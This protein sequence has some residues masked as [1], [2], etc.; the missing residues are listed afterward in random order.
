MGV[1]FKAEHRQMKRVVALKIVS[2]SAIKSRDAL[3]RFY[4]EVE[5]AA[6]LDHPNV[7]PALDAGEARGTHFLVMQYVEGDDLS[8]HVKRRGRLPVDEAVDCILQAAQGLQYAHSRGIIHRDIK[9]ANL[10]LDRQGTVKILDMRL[11]RI[12]SRTDETNADELTNTGAVMGTAAYMSPEQA[13][14]ARHAD[15]RSDIYSLGCTLHYLLTGHP[16]YDGDTHVKQILAHREQP[17]PSLRGIRPEVPESVD[18]IFA[19]MVAKRPVDRFQSMR[20]VVQALSTI[21]EASTTFSGSSESDA[22]GTSGSPEKQLGH[23]PISATGEATPVAALQS[24][25]AD[26]LTTQISEKTGILPSKAPPDFRLPLRGAGAPRH[27]SP[28]WHWREQESGWRDG[29][30]KNPRFSSLRRMSRRSDPPTR[31]DDAPLP[32]SQSR[33][34]MPAKRDDIN[35]NGRTIWNCPPNLKTALE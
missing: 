22:T 35:W 30:A 2:P 18:A 8:W 17:I 29:M 10:L 34:S 11:A 16:V 9:P 27:S 12:D 21:S 26:T 5:T 23:R 24:T 25:D 15:A 1:V 32:R 3:Q 13:L 19:K 4:R 31:R 14:D 6:K 28:S 33:R 20:E 7:V